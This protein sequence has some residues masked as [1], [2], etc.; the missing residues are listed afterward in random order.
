MSPSA[1]EQPKGLNF[2][3]RPGMMPDREVKGALMQRET[4]V[5]YYA[6]IAKVRAITFQNAIRCLFLFSIFLVIF[7]PTMLYGAILSSVLALVTKELRYA[8]KKL[9]Q[10]LPVR[11]GLLYFL[12]V[13]AGIFYTPAIESDRIKEVLVMA[14]PVVFFPL[15][16]PLFANK[17]WQR[18][19]LIALLA[20]GALLAFRVL[21][22]SIG[23][24]QS[25]WGER[26]F[27]FRIHY[28][29]ES[30]A[31]MAWSIYLSLYLTLEAS[32]K[33]AK[34]IYIAL[35]V[36]L[37]IIL[38]GFQGERVGMVLSFIALGIF[39]VQHIRVLHW[40]SLVCVGYFVLF[41]VSYLFS[42][43]TQTRVDA[44][45]NQSYT[46]KSDALAGKEFFS[47]TA[48]RFYT[49][50]AGLNVFL[51]QPLFGYGTGAFS[52]SHKSNPVL[53]GEGLKYLKT[54]TPEVGAVFILMRHGLVGFL[55]FIAFLW[56]WWWVC[57][58]LGF[59]RSALV[60]TALIV[61]LLA[62]CSFPLFYHSRSWL[63][64]FAVIISVTGSLFEKRKHENLAC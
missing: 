56:S 62:D 30:A 52:M 32:T 24:M 16:I 14:L 35:A 57:R 40:I 53:T 17:V 61:L 15:L 42:P 20:S 5:Q 31:L 13:L 26:V 41:A 18:R 3:E 34:G 59:N 39:C 37:L 50:K 1:I 12:I 4:A 2:R 44:L 48:L 51:K 27:L 46:I 54:T 49:A 36:F 45:I 6:A 43:Q 55:V 22:E 60:L 64:L 47:S 21:A 58:P 7:S 29:Q 23:L 11:L 9:W 8:Q 33:I 63:W 19:L 28:I 25:T 38:L 10:M